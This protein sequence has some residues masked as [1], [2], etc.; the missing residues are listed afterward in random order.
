MPFREGGTDK[1]TCVPTSLIR[2]TASPSTAHGFLGLGSSQQAGGLHG[3]PAVPLSLSAAWF[4]LSAVSAADQRMAKTRGEQVGLEAL[5]EQTGSTSSCSL[6]AE[7]G[8][9]QHLQDAANADCRRLCAGRGW[10]ERSRPHS[11]LTHDVHLQMIQN[12]GNRV[13]MSVRLRAAAW[14]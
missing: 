14:Q 3:D 1:P 11:I 9:V 12:G 13:G 10:V 6:E 5:P 8:W 7:A 4:C 2:P